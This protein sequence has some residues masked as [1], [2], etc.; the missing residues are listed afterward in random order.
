MLGCPKYNHWPW[1]SPLIAGYSDLCL[2]SLVLWLSLVQRHSL[3]HSVGLASCCQATTSHS[4]LSAGH[5]LY[6]MG[7]PVLTV[8][9]TSCYHT[10]RGD[11]FIS[12]YPKL[13]LTGLPCCDCD[14]FLGKDFIQSL[15]V[16]AV[17]PSFIISCTFLSFDVGEIW[18]R[19]WVHH[20][21][22]ALCVWLVKPQFNS[23]VL[24]QRQCTKIFLI[25][26]CW[27]CG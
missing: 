13:L 19:C 15:S 22:E 6:C 14:V 23:T 11:L 24:I 25:G 8:L 7:A 20:G 5:Q 21:T 1:L 26:I 3:L 10:S 2:T 17:Q 18:K 12:I 4:Y 27:G 16:G 9:P